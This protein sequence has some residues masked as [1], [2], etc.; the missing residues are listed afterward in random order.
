[1]FQ[2]FFGQDGDVVNKEIAKK[3]PLLPSDT[4]YVKIK[5]EN[6]F[7]FV[8]FIINKD[9]ILVVFPKHFF[10]SE[11]IKE[12]DIK[13]N[14]RLLFKVLSKYVFENKN[15]PLAE[16]YLGYEENYESDYP[17]EEFF[18]IY[19]HYRKYGI[20]KDEEILI[21]KN[22]S[23]KTSW[24]DTI[25]KSNVIVSNKNLIFLPL[26][27]KRKNPKDTFIGQC[28]TFVI[29]HTLK[30]FPFFINLP[31]VK[32]S[33]CK[34]NFLTNR[35]YTLRKLYQYKGMVFKDY[36]KQLIEY[37]IAFFEKYNKISSSGE[38]H[39]KINYFD[40]VWEKMVNKYLNEC[41]IKVDEENSKLIFEYN[42]SNET[43]K[44]VSKT[45]NIDVSDNK[46][47]IRPDH[48][49]EEDNTIYVFDSKYYT[50]IS[51]LNY[52][53]YTYT[54]LLGNSQMKSN[55]KLYS[56][57]LLPGKNEGRFHVKLDS[58]YCQLNPGCNYII[59]QYLDVKTLMKNYIEKWTYATLIKDYN[60]TVQSE[61]KI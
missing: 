10:D 28:M 6:I 60:E 5:K 49:C 40:K 35:E 8:G 2:I 3:F 25:Q 11:D 9:K 26:Y 42:R 19:E 17:F 56:A 22:Y 47:S 21:Q 55:K 54:I 50:D 15:H 20:Y 38:I 59:E 12:E 14:I 45:F 58:Q 43:K 4:R 30:G 53:Q 39:I 34:I 41:F 27:S 31:L 1:M 24:K 18:K 33:G 37:L 48:Y 32:E 44:F 46:Y 13:E 7:D 57:L 36:Q 52:K 29:N 16:K 61:Q 23:G 51:D